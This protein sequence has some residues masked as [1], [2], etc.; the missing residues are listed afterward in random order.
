VTEGARLGLFQGFGIEIEYMIV[1][2]A[3]LDVASVA[4]ELITR[5]AGSL[6][7][8]IERGDAR[9]SNEL[10]AHVI[11]FK[12]NGPLPSLDGAAALFARQVHDANALLARDGRCLLPGGM[13][14]WMDPEREMRLWPHGD[15]RIYSAFDRIF[16]CRGHGWSN[17][18]SVHINLPFDGDE[19]FARLHGAI[20][21]VL[22][23]LPALA[24]SSPIVDGRLTGLMDSRLA[25]YRR[26]CARVPS[27]TGRVIPEAVFSRRD[28]EANILEPMWRDIAPLDPDAVLREEWLNARGA[29]ARFDRMAIEIR[30][31]DVQENPRADLAVVE[32]VVATVRALTQGRWCDPRALRV[33]AV[34]PLAQLF[35]ACVTDAERTPLGWAR[36]LDLFDLG[37]APVRTAGELWAAVALRLAGEGCLSASSQQVLD[38]VFSA[39][40]LARRIAAACA[41]GS[42]ARM[43]AAYQRLAHCLAS[44]EAFR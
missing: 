30:V 12:S 1:D 42:R 33:L 16:D 38:T 24:A 19:E 21:A 4:D 39:G 25:V 36:Y 26:N 40:C 14:P 7:N 27:I 32:L 44:G 3:S 10:V 6:S 5:A 13:H 9:W 34:E 11:E 15:D 43:H 8:E 23:V 2:A 28:Y 20:R 41:D 31:L 22:P 29:I 37:S 35:D 17:L 18:Q